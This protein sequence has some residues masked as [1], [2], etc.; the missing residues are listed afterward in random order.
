[1][2]TVLIADDDADIR[3]LVVF[4]LEQA[5]HRALAVSNGLSAVEVAG[6]SLPDVAI[7]D[8]TMPGMDG[9]EVCAALRDDARTA[10]IPVILL[11]AR[12]QA[13]DTE[14][15]IKAGATEYVTKPFSPRDLVTLVER[16]LGAQ[17]PRP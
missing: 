14:I 17:A 16:I 4:K 9:L 6:A 11:T 5:G 7:I 8:V 15:G 13:A 2:G 10:R 1:M 3:E 12:A